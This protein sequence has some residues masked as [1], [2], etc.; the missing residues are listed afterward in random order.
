[1][2]AVSV[3]PTPARPL[4]RAE[5]IAV[6]S[7]LL[8]P[9]RT[10]TNSLYLTRQLNELGIEVRGKSIV[11]DD[12][13]EL[14]QLL[15]HVMARAELILVSGGLGPTDDDVTR[16]TVADVLALPLDER[17]DLMAWIEGRFTARGLTM[18]DVNRRQAMVPRGAAVLENRRGTAPGLWIEHGAHVLVLLPGPPRELEPMFEAAVRPRLAA[19]SGG[20]R[21]V[22][23]VLR[24][25]GRTESHVEEA[26]QPIYAPWKDRVPRIDTTV[27]AAPGQIELHLSVVTDSEA[28]AR[29]VLDE[30]T[31]A[32]RAALGADLFSAEG[33]TLEEVVGD[34]LRTR[35]YRIA[36]AE[37]CTGGAI[38]SRLTDVAG[39][40]DYVERGFVTYSNQSKVELLGVSAR[41]LEE[42]G[43]VSEPVA[44][45]MADG[46][47]RR[48]GVDVGV[49]VTGIAGP[50]GGT[51]QKPVGTVCVAV[52]IGDD[53]PRVRTF[54]FPGSRTQIKFQAS[55][56]ALDMVRRA[57]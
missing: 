8:T 41:L 7:E 4:A 16:E 10:D 35:G 17:P 5:I 21:L 49:G 1:M 42:H 55:Q 14:A 12:R 32:L 40:S 52:A 31:E 37:S 6:G 26:V 43:A 34:L 53:A 45:A 9:F 46:A 38:S 44:L 24:I 47:R 33:H 22:R 25:A 36:V 27:L 15:R 28:A 2:D 30:A 20:G 54:R 11:G 18:P 13:A 48:A 23:R 39:S 57:L 3:S 19:R 56:A 50:G 51:V 29:V